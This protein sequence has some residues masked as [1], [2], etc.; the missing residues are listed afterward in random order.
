MVGTEWVSQEE[1]IQ[2]VNDALQ[3][4]DENI[5]KYKKEGNNAEVFR[6]ETDK[7]VLQ[8]MLTS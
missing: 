2:K 3:K 1:F 4:L 5:E 6:A 7:T 8:G